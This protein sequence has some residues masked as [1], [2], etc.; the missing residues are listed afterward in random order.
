MLGSQIAD[1]LLANGQSHV[2][3]LVR[4]LPSKAAALEPLV[5]RGLELVE[6]DVT[7]PETLPAAVS[8]VHV[9]ISALNN[10]PELI[11]A[12][13]TNLLRAAEAAGT[14]T[15][16]VPSDF[17]GDFRK[18]QL[19]DNYNLDMRIRFHEVLAKSPI[20]YTS[21]LNGAFYE[22]IYA[23]FLELFDFRNNTFR[24]WGDRDQKMDFTHTSDAARY[25]A[26]AALDS[27]L[28]N[29]SMNVAGAEL[30]YGELHEAFTRATG[31]R[32]NEVRMGSIA[33]LQAEIRRRQATATQPWAYLGL[34][35]IYMMASGLGKLDPVMNGRYPEI[36]P[37][38]IGDFLREN[39]PTAA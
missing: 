21:I 1:A 3:A 27:G 14:V 29:Q 4:D 16:F 9:V 34:Q 13:Q 39:A 6:G 35:Y 26:L 24:Y 18:L 17:S 19:G 23:P 5:S 30:S 11:I 37:M 7:R 10:Q 36:R 2:R 15:R 8:G 12:G 31:R 22:V 28:A 32:L 38:P 25:T 33:D 20:P